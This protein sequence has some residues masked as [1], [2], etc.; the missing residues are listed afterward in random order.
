LPQSRIVSIA[1]A[2]AYA[3]LLHS[4]PAGAATSYDYY[5]QFNDSAWLS[6]A[7]TKLEAMN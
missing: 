4:A 6:P 5:T 3:D 1:A 2:S 7:V